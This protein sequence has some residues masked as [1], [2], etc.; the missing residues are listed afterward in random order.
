MR[1]PYLYL[2]NIKHAG[3]NP[4]AAYTSIAQYFKSFHPENEPEY[5]YLPFFKYLSEVCLAAHTASSK[6]SSLAAEE[7]RKA[8]VK[9]YRSE[10]WRYFQLY[11]SS[12]WV[13]LK[14]RLGLH[15]G[16]SLDSYEG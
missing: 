3:G 11:L 14:A 16:E 9:V 4:K 5:N 2:E 8:K 1:S 6:L 10:A 12:C 13:S 15:K 7:D